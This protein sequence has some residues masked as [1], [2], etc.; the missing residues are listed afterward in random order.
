ETRPPGAEPDDGWRVTLTPAHWRGEGTATVE[1]RTVAGGTSV[2]FDLAGDERLRIC[3]VLQT[4]ARH[5]PIPVT[6]NGYAVEQELFLGNCV[7]TKAFPG[8]RVGA[9]P[10]R[11]HARNPN[12]NFHGVTARGPEAE[13]AS[14][15]ELVVHDGRTFRNPVTYNALFDIDDNQGIALVLPAR[16]SVIEDEKTHGMVELASRFLWSTMLE[17][18]PGIHVTAADQQRI[19]A[20]GLPPPADPPEQLEPWT[21]QTAEHHVYGAAVQA[22]TPLPGGAW[23]MEAAHDLEP[24][25]QA[26]VGRALK[27]AGLAGTVFQPDKTLDG[28]DWYDRLPRIRRVTLSVVTA[29][30]ATDLEEIRRAGPSWTKSKVL[31]VEVRLEISDGRRQTLETDLVFLAEDGPWEPDLHV[32]GNATIDVDDLTDL[33]FDAWFS[34]SDDIEAESY[35]TQVQAYRDHARHT[36]LST[37][38]SPDAADEDD[39][40]ER[41][42]RAVSGSC[43]SPGDTVEITLLERG[44]PDIRIAHAGQ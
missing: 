7:A 39:L 42:R 44:G 3:S 40:M 36:A 26:V 24:P 31:E 23:V 38:E 35:E 29:D 28:Y 16:Q 11:R 43:L 5:Y 25:D 1:P 2:T 20:L 15:Y 9:T 22:A 8:G 19:K 4:A 27:Q 21:A 41:L 34:P 10:G 18:H 17:Q 32:T 14:G 13:E 33:I 12:Y 6:I 37:L 30:G